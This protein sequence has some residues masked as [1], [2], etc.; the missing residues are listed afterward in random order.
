MEFKVTLKSLRNVVST[1]T[2]DSSVDD[3]PQRISS[4]ARF[5][6]AV[7]TI[8]KVA[9]EAAEDVTEVR[10]F[11]NVFD[12]LGHGLN[13]SRV[14]NYGSEVKATPMEDAEYEDFNDNVIETQ[15]THPK[16]N[17]VM[18]ASQTGT[19]FGNKDD[20]SLMVQYSVANDTNE[21][22]RNKVKDQ[23]PTATGA[24]TV[25]H[26]NTITP[27]VDGQ[28]Q[29]IDPRKIQEYFEDFYEDIYEELHKF[30]EIESLNICNNLAD[31]MVGNV[32][33]QFTEEDQAA[34]ALKALQG[35]FYSG[36]PIIA[37][38]SPVTDFREAMCRQFEENNCNRGGYYNFMHVKQIGRDLR[39]KL[40]GSY[41]R[42]SRGSRSR[43]RSMSPHRRRHSEGLGTIEIEGITME[44][45]EEVLTGMVDMT[46]MVGED[47]MG[48]QGTPEVL[49]RRG[50]R[51]GGRRLKSGTRKGRGGTDSEKS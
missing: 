36:S 46:A 20:D 6:S 33:V 41:H 37:D 27:G 12:R 7:T 47:D 8:F 2:R 35:H 39:K 49:Q 40:Y 18:S 51:N 26:P 32:Y 34:A 4:V 21:L 42:R 50:V 44:I 38:F 13:V 24:T 25:N 10:G 5:P 30:G 11:A 23:N 1:S 9:A 17:K 29:P 15:S 14:T 48:A 3:Q 28:G 45:A 22:A 43:S 31:H 19:S 16:R